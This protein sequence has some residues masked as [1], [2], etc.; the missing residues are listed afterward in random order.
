MNVGSPVVLVVE[1]DAELLNF[2]LENL[3]ADG[4]DPYGLGDPEL[5][6]DYCIR[7]VPDMAIVSINGGSG[8]RLVAEVRQQHN[9]RVDHRLP[10]IL[11]GHDSGDVELVRNLLVGADNY[12]AKP[13]AYSA[14]LARSRALLRRVDLDHGG[15]SGSL[16]VGAIVIDTTTR[17]VTVDGE[18]AHTSQKTYA[19]LLRLAQAP[20][21]VFTK[22]QLLRDIWGHD[23]Q[24]STRTLET[25]ACHLR[26][27]LRVTGRTYV[28]NLHGVGYRLTQPGS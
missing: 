15:V 4:F 17:S 5:F 3:A 27:A 1:E 8:R 20:D 16:R 11:T 21:R 19:L 6:T 26:R 22:S 2:L 7:H 23:G 12:L 10:V 13:F 25:H 14:L 24:C 18:P 9:G 28:H